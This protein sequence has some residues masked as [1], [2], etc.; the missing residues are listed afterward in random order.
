MRQTAPANL[1]F[2]ARLWPF[3]VGLLFV[4]QIFLPYKGWTILLV[5]L[6]GVWLISYIWAKS[7]L[8]GLK[9][10]REIRFGWAQVGDHIEERFTIINDSNFPALWLEILDHST[11]PNYTCSQVTGIESLTRTSWLTQGI[12]TQRGVFT[13]GPT[14]LQTG[15][16]FGLYTVTV[17]YSDSTT[18]TVMPP[19]LALPT[20]QISPGGRMGEGRPRPTMLERTVSCSSVREYVH[21]DSMQWV[22]WPTSARRGALYVRQ[23]DSM[24]S[25]DWWIF[26]DLAQDV[27]V[28]QGDASTI[29][30]AIVL[31]A[32]LAGQGLALGRAVGLVT[33]GRGLVWLSPFGGDSQRWKILQALAIAETGER[34]LAELLT[35]ARP[36]FG[37]ISSL[38]IITPDISGQWIEA[39]LPLLRRGAVPTVLLFDPVSFGSTSHKS[40]GTKALLDDLGVTCHLITK[41]LLDRPEARPGEQGHW[42]WRVTPS[43]RTIA[44]QQPRDTAWK[45]LH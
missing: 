38:V 31:A 43:G 14:S 4:T 20:I 16:P 36:A 23:F 41:D 13:L 25:G 10:S 6:G 12:C 24:P 21:G 22:H 7:L 1:K 37:Q 42:K 8:Q 3:L 44:V 17:Q 32:S 35:R 26:L 11:I 39:M 5:S 9:L 33:H 28:G 45:K 34:S 40:G 29:E 15:D 18:L 30:H 2:K 19:I 27:Q